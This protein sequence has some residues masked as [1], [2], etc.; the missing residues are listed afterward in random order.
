MEISFQHTNPREGHESTLLHVSTRD[1]DTYSYLIDA[2]ESV[3]TAAFLNTD[4]ELDGVFLTHAH[5]DH[6]ASLSQILSTASD[7]QLYT[8][9]GTAA[10]LEDVYT[11]ADRYQDLGDVT[12]I[13]EALTPIDTWTPLN[14]GVFVLPVPAG[15]TLGAAGFL[16]RIDDPQNNETVTVL[17][18]GDFTT[19]PVG[20]YPS[21]TIPGSIDIDILIANAATSPHF[22]DDLNDALE[23]LL[24]RGLSG[25]TT[26]VAAS[27][28]TGVHTAYLLGHILNEIDRQ[29]PIHLAGQAA[30]IYTTLDYDIP[31]VSAH[32]QF[33]HTDEVLAAGAITIAGPEAPTQGSIARLYGVIEDDPDAV[34]VQLTTSGVEAVDGGECATHY[35]KLANHPTKQQFINTVET[36]LPRHLIFKHVQPEHSKQLGTNFNN[37]FHWSNDDTQAHILY[38]DGD[39]PGPP[40]VDDGTASRIRRRNYQQS[41]SRLP[42]DRPIDKLPTLSLSRRPPE[43]SAEGVEITQFKDHYESIQSVQQQPNDESASGEAEQESSGVH[44]DSEDPNQPPP[45]DTQFLTD[46]TERLDALEAMLDDI[47]DT[48]PTEETVTSRIDTLEG[49]IENIETDISDLP[50]QINSDD[51]NTISSTVLRQGDLV[52]FRVNPDALADHDLSLSHEQDAELKIVEVSSDQSKG[53]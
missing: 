53:N 10:M 11:E 31:S 14:D 41:G 27:A 48:I 50:E 3:S 43:L 20:G 36:N 4:D 15:H 34:F 17:T 16:F 47:R 8:S 19:R 5:T 44:P 40:W 2:G 52:L 23:V 51:R 38:D 32:P 22:E 24:E 6:Y 12:H 33:E 25:A 13:T 28:L 46:I 35:A 18:T 45:I 21:L 39:W 37:L 26:L 30:K 7:T 1:D 29:L 42:I 9:P 49:R